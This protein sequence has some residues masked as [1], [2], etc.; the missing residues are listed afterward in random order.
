MRAASSPEHGCGGILASLPSP[1]SSNWPCMIGGGQSCVGSIRTA[2]PDPPGEWRASYHKEH[3]VKAPV[4]PAL[5]NQPQSCILYCCN[6][7]V[8]QFS[9]P[10]VF[11]HLLLSLCTVLLIHVLATHVELPFFDR[12]SKC[13]ILYILKYL[14]YLYTM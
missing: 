10:D 14:P 11:L 13:D 2:H 9:R 6:L 12:M 5:C 8:L 3:D 4:V 7:G 1:A